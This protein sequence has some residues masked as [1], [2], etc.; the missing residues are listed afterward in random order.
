M[1]YNN[2]TSQ[3][4]ARREYSDG[5]LV[6]R[7]L[8]GT[9]RCIGAVV[10]AP[11]AFPSQVRRSYDRSI[12]EGGFIGRFANGFNAM[13]TSL[14]AASPAVIAYTIANAS[15]EVD[16]RKLSYITTAAALTNLISLGYEIVRAVRNNSSGR[17]SNRRAA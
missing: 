13:L 17:D 11:I 15:G 10:R 16:P 9:A 14:A 1:N 8:G 12:S 7:I 3:D 4:E 5:G 2:R 6:P